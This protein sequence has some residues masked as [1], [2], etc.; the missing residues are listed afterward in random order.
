MSELYPDSYYDVVSILEI[1]HRDGGGYKEYGPRKQN[2]S[3]K[4]YREVVKGSR[5]T[6]DL[7]ILCRVCNALHFV[8]TKHPE[9][10]GHFVVGFTK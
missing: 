1:N 4:F 5:K 10:K 2:P 7:N 8:E 3:T 6:D 9:L